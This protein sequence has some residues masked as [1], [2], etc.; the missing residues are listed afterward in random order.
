[1]SQPHVKMWRSQPANSPQ[2]I[3]VAAPL[4]S[5][6]GD[7]DSQPVW[8]TLRVINDPSHTTIDDDIVDAAEAMTAI[9]DPENT[10]AIP[11]E[12]VKRDLK[13]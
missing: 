3:T 1:M 2:Q 5:Y 9:L 4:S 11:W 6:V 13:L 10:G 8:G 12:Q 7:L